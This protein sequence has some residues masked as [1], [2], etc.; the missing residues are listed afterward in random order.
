MNPHE[1]TDYKKNTKR[2]VYDRLSIYSATTA[3]ELS[4]SMSYCPETI[5]KYLNILHKE[6]L[7]IKEN[8]FG[9]LHYYKKVKGVQYDN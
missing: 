7:I 2:E 9:R 4:R 6:G 5:K 3:K 1:I 8:G